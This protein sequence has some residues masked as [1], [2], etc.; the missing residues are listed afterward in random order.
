[1]KKCFKIFAK[2]LQ[3]SQQKGCAGVFFQQSCRP[4]ARKFTKK[5]HQHIATRF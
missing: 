3:N 4:E 5:I 2:F 1:M